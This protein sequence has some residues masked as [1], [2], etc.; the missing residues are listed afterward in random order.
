MLHYNGP[1]VKMI[2]EQ[3]FFYPQ[4]S[5]NVNDIIVGDQLFYKASDD[6]NDR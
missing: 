3:L 1:S 6:D 2:S 5:L 4:R